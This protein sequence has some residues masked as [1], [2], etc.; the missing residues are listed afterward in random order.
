MKITKSRLTNTQALCIID[1]WL[2][3]A[4]IPHIVTNRGD[5]T[6][7]DIQVQKKGSAE[8]V[9]V[10]VQVNRLAASPAT[11]DLVVLVEDIMS[12]DR[13]EALHAFHNITAAA[14]W[15]R[16]SPVVD[17]GPEPRVKSHDIHL[18]I[19]RHSEFRNAPNLSEK[20]FREVYD[21]DITFM[22]RALLRDIGIRY[23]T[24]RAGES[25]ESLFVIGRLIACNF[26]HRYRDVRGTQAQ[27]RTFF[28][29]H[30][31]QRIKNAVTQWRRHERN[32][33]PDEQTVSIALHGAEFEA[34][35]STHMCFDLPEDH[36]YLLD[37]D[38]K[39]RRKL[40]DEEKATR[41]RLVQEQ[42]DRRARQ[43][44]MPGLDE[45]LSTVSHTKRIALLTE[46]ATKDDRF[47]D[48]DVKRV[49]AKKLVEEQTRCTNGCCAAA[50]NDDVEMVEAAG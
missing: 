9:N 7:I 13:A 34:E 24:Q 30:L 39:Q 37:L 19:I 46:F 4:K 44:A 22:T 14:G 17:R 35:P 31:K 49:A 15:G 12:L 8:F 43:K 26:H 50:A 27:N 5:S 25:F 10:V 6:G 21:T 11:A 18:L 38:V 32:S 29:A 23:V 20:I 40:S 28:R 3:S 16:P 48:P 45:Y 36:T 2:A 33:L 41:V 1:S 42:K 47:C